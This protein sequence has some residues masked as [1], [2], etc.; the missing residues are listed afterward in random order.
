MRLGSK[1]ARLEAHGAFSHQQDRSPNPSS[2]AVTAFTCVRPRPATSGRGPALREASR[3]FLTP[4]EPIWPVDD[5]T[6]PA[7]RRRLRRQDEE[8]ERDETLPFFMFR[9]ATM[10]SW[11]G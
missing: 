7:F 2:S 10:R 3:D 5:L 8:M 6:R 9:Q 11:A 1:F 4:W